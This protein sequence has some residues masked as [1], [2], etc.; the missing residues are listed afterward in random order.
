MKTFYRQVR[1]K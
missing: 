1:T